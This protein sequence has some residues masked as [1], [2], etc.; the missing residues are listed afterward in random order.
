MRE[1]WRTYLSFILVG[2]IFIACQALSGGSPG[3]Q[4][5]GLSAEGGDSSYRDGSRLE[6]TGRG[7]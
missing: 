7:N 2:A 4:S 5:T 3:T 6:T 1:S